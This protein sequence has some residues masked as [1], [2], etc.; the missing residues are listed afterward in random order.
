[1]K[2]RSKAGGKAGTAGR[3]K[4]VTPQ[5]RNAPRT[6][7]RHSSSAETLESQVTRL[8]SELNEAIERQTA[9][10]EILAS[11][12]G[13]TGDTRPVFETILD[14]LLRLFG[15]RFALI[16]LVH[17]GMLHV[18]GLKGEPGFEK[19]A[20]NYPLPLDDRLHAGKAI[21]A[22][23]ALQ[24]VPVIGNAEAA[25]ITQKLGAEFGYNALLSVPMI[26]DGK[27][28]GVLNT[29]HRDPI[30]FTDKQVELIKSFAAQAVIAIE[31][32]RLLNELR[33]SL[34]QQTATAD[35]LKVISRSTFDLQAVLGTL[36]ESATRLCDAQDA[37]IFLPGENVYRA[38]ARYGFTPEF[39]E[40]IKS[41]PITIDRGSVV[42]RTAIEGRVVHVTDV[43]T[44]AKYTLHD[45]QKISGYRA[46]LGVPLLRDRKVV[47][48]I[49]LTRRKPQPFTNKQI[50]LVE[51]FADQAAIAMEN[52]RLFEAEQ[53][54]TRELTEALEQ[55][56][57]TSDVLQV[58]SSSP[59]DLQP[60]FETILEKAVRICGAKFGDI[61]RW[62]DDAL[63]LLATH[64]TPPAFVEALGRLQ[65]LRSTDSATFGRRMVATKSVIHVSDLAAE[66]V[67]TERKSPIYIAAVELG[68]VRTILLVPMLK[69]NELIG[70]FVLCRQEVRPFRDKQIEL[71]TTFAAQ[72]VIAIENARLL[73]ELRESLQQQTATADVL[74]VI[75]RSTFDLQTV[76]QTLV[77]SAAR[78]CE[79]DKAAI[80]R[81]RGEVFYRAEAYG[82]SD[83]F[84]DYVRSIP[85]AP[86]RGS[87]LG[88]VLLE[89]RVVHIA[90][91]QAD[92]EYTFVEGQRLGDFRTV[93]GVPMLREGIPIGV[94]ALTRSEVRPFTD[95]QIE[96]VSIFADQAA[97]AIENARLLNELRQR[98][99]DLTER[100]ANLTEALEQQTATSEVLQV[101]SSS[102]GDLE[103]V[104]D[105]MLE[106]AVR[107][108]DAKFGNVYRRDG[109]A[110]H[111]VAT[112]NT[113]PAFAEARKR[114]P[115]HRL[116][117]ES[118]LGHMATT[119][120]V[121]H[122]AD[123]AADQSYIEY[124]VPET[125]AAVEL[126]GVRTLLAVPM[127][128]ENELIGAFTLLRQEVRPFTDKQIALVTNFAAQA[129]IAIE[130]ARLLNELRQRTN[131]L[132]EA[133]EQQTATA[134]VLQVISSSPGDPQPVFAA[135]L[136][137][138]VRITDATFGGLYRWD[139]EFLHH[140][141]THNT[142]AALAE[143]RRRSP[144][145]RPDPRSAAG[146]MVAAK[147]VIHVADVTAEP[148]Y[149]EGSNPR[150]V[151]AVRLGG[152][153]TIVAV[154]MLK[155]DELVGAILM[156]R[157]EVRPF[158]DKQIELVENF[159]A[160]A[161][162]AIENARLLNEL[163]QR[164][165]ELVRS[166]GE[167]RAL[168]EVSQAVNSTLD[169]QTVLSTIVAK[170]V[171][172]SGTEAGAIYVFDDLQREFHLRAT[173]G[174]DQELIDVLTQR[175]I[176]MDDPNVAQALAQPEPIQV[177]DLREEAP[178]DLNEITLR[179][180][181]RARLVA[182]LLRGDDVVGLLVVRRRTP[183]AF[184]QNTVDLIKTFAAQ[185]ALAIQN[186]RLFHEIEDKG[187][188][189]EVASKHKSQFLAN[190]SHELRTPLNAI[191]GYTE[192]ILDNIYGEAPEKMRSVLERVQTNGKH[193]L[194]LINDVL[195]M[196]KI[197]AGQVTLSLSH[198]SLEE[199]ING[200]YV[201]VEPLAAQKKLTLRTSIPPGLP[202]G[203]G[204]ERRLAQVLLNLVGNA[205]KFT[206]A[207]EVAIEASHSDGSFRV[208]VRDSGPGIAAADQA[209]IFEEFQ[210]VDNTPTRQ[211]GGTGLGLAI[212]KRIVEMH[213]G[214]ILVDS[215]LGKGSTFTISIPVN[216]GGE[217]R[218][219]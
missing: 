210:Q 13:S 177:A 74:K 116:S 211:K 166:V 130:N 191:L 43:L 111:L 4:A 37:F 160:Q 91:V 32:A 153:R 56:T 154:P 20:E 49:F 197:E 164:T 15:T 55:Q 120:A 1:M 184:P 88:R 98:T 27:V 101:I 22:G 106:N 104:F 44:D 97:I 33:E 218:T 21:L 31:N 194:G 50:E 172:L 11:I 82:F 59:G 35:V 181:Y 10:A 128:K 173:Y 14:N 2:R 103:P 46:A 83:E 67:Y 78:L 38:V 42:G 201:A 200:V 180:G 133:L 45:A 175:R 134:E 23:R 110:L 176:G 57:A 155:E 163:R 156:S 193:L 108:C 216:A 203:H 150:Y 151:A 118:F 24:I 185:S 8:S 141:A 26:H 86:D 206:E 65:P 192:L 139:G 107:I 77:E 144:S 53:Q 100:T 143:Y 76:L 205:I 54:R 127:L 40:Y 122:V 25:A 199:L 119:K 145:W 61:Y 165:D 174:M 168:G 93:L 109:N 6:M 75:S 196:S 16:L 80:T 62:E 186:A 135:M 213:G 89:G 7:S 112:H 217:A 94:L 66:Q 96:L 215:E 105:K 5:R 198:Y 60:V 195:D 113:P 167:L 187:R 73:N 81:Q 204:D 142:P 147:S 41:N 169:L 48:V 152:A 146:R 182:P 63:R 47:G 219:A 39:H 161:V 149:I 126:G 170:A 84:L 171:Q 18:A 102:P 92:P 179:A 212:S 162:I 90:D 140:I 125:V 69:E 159:A 129:I 70:A 58:I 95:K 36:V 183:G 51:T 19:F 137:K 209:K 52:V 138:A 157:Q 28:V 188:Q 189:L 17:D 9:T 124:R 12:S 71:V 136:E 64:N 72:A 132:S 29:A 148:A 115:H 85:V 30:P 79:A 87:A 208:A 202:V 117:P 3:R 190:M 121:V 207:G 131:D 99:D 158:T 68:G 34:Q 178:S 214:R 123:I 114:S